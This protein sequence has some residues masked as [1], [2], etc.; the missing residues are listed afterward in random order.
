MVSSD[1]RLNITAGGQRRLAHAL[2]PVGWPMSPAAAG[3]TGGL[4]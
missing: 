2:A 4:L 3:L 1:R